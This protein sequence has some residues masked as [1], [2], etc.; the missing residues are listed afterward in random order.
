MSKSS[1]KLI[2]T[3]FTF[4]GMILGSSAAV[5][6]PVTD[7]N[8][9]RIWQGAT[10]G[11]FAQLFYGSDTL[12]NRQAVVNSGLLDDGTFGFVGATPAP[13]ITTDASS[14]G[15]ST[16]V[17]PGNYAYVQPGGTPTAAG[18]AVD[19]SWLQTTNVIGGTVWDLGALSAKAA[20][21]NT[22]DHGPLPGEAIESTVY[23]SAGSAGP[24]VQAV[25]QK[26]WLEGYSTAI[27]WDGFVYAVGTGTNDLFRYATIIHGGP[28]SLLADGDNEIN[29]VLGLD[30]NFNPNPAVPIPGALPLFATGL[31]A[32]GYL[33]YRRRRKIAS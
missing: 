15:T 10:V 33:A 19:A 12:A 30:A 4:S 18:S 31:G 13:I 26:V 11:T 24:W 7:P 28:G 6:A 27:D 29:G 21:F 2:A 32:F 20:I 22:I 8:D 1:A 17:G 9:P 3:L 16:G 5:A 23:L 25:T 14:T